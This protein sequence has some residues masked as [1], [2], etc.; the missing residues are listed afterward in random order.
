MRF[1]IEGEKSN[2]DHYPLLRCSVRKLN[3]DKVVVSILLEECL[4]QHFVS[5]WITRS[6]VAIFIHL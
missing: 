5:D 6:A 1:R 2:V 3:N 4:L